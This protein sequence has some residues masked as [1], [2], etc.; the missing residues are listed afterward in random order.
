MSIHESSVNFKNLIKDLADIYPY[1]VD[2]VILVE[3]IA[4][5]LDAKAN[6]VSIDY[7]PENKVLVV[8]DDGKGMNSDTFEEYHDFAAGLKTRGTGIGFAGVV[9]RL[10]GQVLN[11]QFLLNQRSNIK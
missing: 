5:A 4:N 6:N 2:E 11:Y 9:E 10:G 3:L 1:D 7:D 8:F